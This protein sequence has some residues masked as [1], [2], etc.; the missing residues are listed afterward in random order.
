V[1]PKSK[2]EVDHEKER[3]KGPSKDRV[4]SVMSGGT[5]QFPCSPPTTSPL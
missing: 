3:D 4:P 2:A 1:M 5:G